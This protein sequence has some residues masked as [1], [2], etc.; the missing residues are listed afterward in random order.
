VL[1]K[2]IRIPAVAVFHIQFSKLKSPQ[3]YSNGDCCKIAGKWNICVTSIYVCPEAYVIGFIF[4]FLP[5]NR[6]QTVLFRR[7]DL[8]LIAIIPSL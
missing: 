7:V 8:V 6:A 3:N 5:P 1:R 2:F 4:T